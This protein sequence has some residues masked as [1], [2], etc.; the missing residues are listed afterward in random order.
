MVRMKEILAFAHCFFLKVNA[1][2]YLEE[3]DCFTP[4]DMILVIQDHDRVLGLRQVSLERCHC[5]QHDIHVWL[6]IFLQLRHVKG[7][8]I[9]S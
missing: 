3:L 8:V 9:S 2:L 5:R 6:Q 4:H 1:P 7:V